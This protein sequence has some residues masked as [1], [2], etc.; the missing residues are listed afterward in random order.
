MSSPDMSISLVT[1]RLFLEEA[2]RNFPFRKQATPTQVSGQSNRQ[3]RGKVVERLNL[4][5]GSGGVLPI[6][7]SVPGW[8]FA[9]HGEVRSHEK[10]RLEVPSFSFCSALHC[11][12]QEVLL[13][14]SEFWECR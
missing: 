12:F 1:T 8:S 14:D 3:R 7:V 4:V 2:S 13:G 11:Y 5:V 9:D 6:A 10:K